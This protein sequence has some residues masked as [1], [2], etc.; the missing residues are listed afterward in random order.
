MQRNFYLFFRRDIILK[1]FYQLFV[2]EGLLFNSPPPFS[3]YFIFPFSF[4]QGCV[5]VAA[6]VGSFVH[7]GQ[8]SIVGQNCV[9]KDCCFIQPDSVLMP[10]TVVPP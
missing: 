10:D 4:L 9:V 7:I 5:V 8:N 3:T 2:E 6:Y 1:G